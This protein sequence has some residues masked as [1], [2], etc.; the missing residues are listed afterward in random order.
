MSIALISLLLGISVPIYRTMQ[1]RT[2]S[3]QTVQ[4]TV[5]TLRAA[6]LSAM[7]AIDDSN[8]GVYFETQTVTLF[9]GDSY[10]DRSLADDQVYVVVDSVQLSGT[11]EIIFYSMTGLPDVTGEIDV[12]AA[13]GRTRTA[14]VNRLGM[15]DYD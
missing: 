15:I 11:T 4:V 1:L 2:Y 9:K 13:N 6:Q 3:D 10:A 5:N 7:A 14:T 8:W 12:T